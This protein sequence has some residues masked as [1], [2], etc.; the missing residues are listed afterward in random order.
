[1]SDVR[2]MELNAAQDSVS[3]VMKDSFSN[4]CYFY[5]FLEKGNSLTKLIESLILPSPNII[6][7]QLQ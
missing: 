1:M 2:R 3:G 7:L 4:N 5:T 6:L